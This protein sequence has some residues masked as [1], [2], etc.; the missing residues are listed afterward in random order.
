MLDVEVTVGGESHDIEFPEPYL[1]WDHTFQF[2]PVILD[3]DGLMVCV[4]HLVITVWEGQVC[5]SYMLQAISRFHGSCISHTFASQWQPFGMKL[6]GHQHFG[7]VK[8]FILAHVLSFER[9]STV[10][11]L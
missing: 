10:L 5:L 4:D 3:R 11:W 7:G 9:V 6:V 8:G 1:A 2:R